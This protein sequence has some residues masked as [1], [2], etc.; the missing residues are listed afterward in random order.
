[1]SP[2]MD[3]TTYN[4]SRFQPEGRGYSRRVGTIKGII[5]HTTNGN[6]GST[7]DGE[8]RW[9][10]T[11]L[12][13]SA[14]YLVGKSGQIAQILD[15]V[16]YAA[17][18]AGV[19]TPGWSNQETIGIEC[20][21]AVGDT[22][23]AAQMAALTELVRYL[24]ARF[25]LSP[26]NVTTHRAVA[27][28]AGRKVDPSD[29]GDAAFNA[30]RA[31]LGNTGPTAVIGVAQRSDTARLWRACLR[32]NARLTREE[33]ERCVALATGLGVDMTFVLAL[34]AH[35]SQF[36]NSEICLHTNNPGNIKAVEGEWRAHKVI[37][38][39]W[40]LAYESVQLGLLALILHLKNEYG[41][42]R[43]L[44]TVEDLAHVYAPKDDGNNP[45]RWI[46]AI[47]ENMRYIETH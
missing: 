24:M 7:F 14:E 39:T 43:R 31:T 34:I 47:L 26:A 17:W 45:E 41:W 46:A 20:H 2:T 12:A 42:A 30:W 22:W 38:D 35:E 44:H 27:L 40:W 25:G 11:S 32:N 21:H 13:V 4:K 23:P 15:P 10:A 6:R 3:V 16:R 19:T 33:L 36:G 1:M 29:W 5:I 18:H 9:L 8:A 28:P 37:D